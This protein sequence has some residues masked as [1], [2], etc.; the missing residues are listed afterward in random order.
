MDYVRVVAVNDLMVFIAE[1]VIIQPRSTNIV[2]L[3]CSLSCSSQEELR[4][5]LCRS[6]VFPI[7]QL[8]FGTASGLQFIITFPTHSTS[9]LIL[10][11]EEVPI[12][13]E[14]VKQELYLLP[15]GLL[16]YGSLQLRFEDA[17]NLSFTF[18]SSTL[19]LHSEVDSLHENN[20]HTLKFKPKFITRQPNVIF[21]DAFPD[22]NNF[23]ITPKQTSLSIEIPIRILQVEF[24]KNLNLS[25]EI[26]FLLENFSREYLKLNFYSQV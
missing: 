15:D 22:Y 25:L 20:P 4:A 9:V 3:K 14:I 10:P 1:N 16:N 19:F 6:S 13:Y 12:L 24:K 11:K 21:I 18:S 23:L 26:Y 2:A 8:E 17:R 5:L 7:R